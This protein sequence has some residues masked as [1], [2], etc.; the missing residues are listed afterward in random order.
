MAV[1][2]MAGQDTSLSG[3]GGHTAR[4]RRQ[5]KQT[6]GKL[7]GVVIL[8]GCRRAGRCF[9]CSAP[10]PYAL[11]NVRVA[12]VLAHPHAPLF[13]HVVSALRT[14]AILATFLVEE[15]PVLRLLAFSERIPRLLLLFFFLLFGLRLLLGEGRDDGDADGGCKEGG[16]AQET[17][18]IN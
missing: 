6:P 11:F 10:A 9:L 15:F 1:G 2:L 8:C 17:A 14:D 16:A 3:G 5:Q 18:A 12:T 4:P 7:P 13:V